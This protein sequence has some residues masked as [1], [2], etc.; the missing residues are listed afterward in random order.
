[1]TAS[2]LHVQA[3]FWTNRRWRFAALF[4]EGEAAGRSDA[5]IVRVDALYSAVRA[6]GLAMTTDVDHLSLRPV[7]GWRIL[8]NVAGAITLRWPHFHPLLREAPIAL[9]RGWAEAVNEQGL[10]LLFVGH[11]F[12]LHEHAGD[13]PV[14]AAACLRHVAEHGALAAGAVIITDRPDRHLRTPVSGADGGKGQRIDRD[15]AQDR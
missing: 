5:G 10:V 6:R 15:T 3:G 11:G 7:P 13:G 9:P 14:D 8:V 4:M 2:E 12:G 1:M